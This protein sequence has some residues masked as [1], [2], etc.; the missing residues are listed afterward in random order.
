M[1]GPDSQHAKN[2]RTISVRMERDNALHARS[3]FLSD[4]G[5]ASAI[6]QNVVTL[7]TETGWDQLVEV[8]ETILQFVNFTTRAAP[9]MMMVAFTSGFVIGDISGD[10]HGIQPLFSQKILD[11]AVNRGNS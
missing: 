7:E 11:G 3:L 2:G 1:R 5:T 10:L 6:E 8:G 4:A 9:E